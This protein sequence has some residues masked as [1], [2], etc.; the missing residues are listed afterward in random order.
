MVV[1]GLGVVRE[2]RAGVRAGALPK[3]C[4][5]GPSVWRDSRSAL[6]DNGG[7]TSSPGEIPAQQV[8]AHVDCASKKEFLTPLSNGVRIVLT[9]SG[10]GVADF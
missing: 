5:V 3:A 8:A 9:P 6:Q 7:H 4:D 10:N 2:V 1:A